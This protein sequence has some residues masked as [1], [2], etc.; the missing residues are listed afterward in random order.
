LVKTSKS[1]PHASRLREDFGLL[2]YLSLCLII[3]FIGPI[4]RLRQI[5]ASAICFTGEEGCLR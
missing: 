4:K 5:F 3:L 2:F 1:G